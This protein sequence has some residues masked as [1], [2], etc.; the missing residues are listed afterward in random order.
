LSFA[1]SSLPTIDRLEGLD[2]ACFFVFEDERPVRGAAGLVDW[3]LCGALSRVLI[4][5]RFAGAMGDALLFPSLGRVP[6]QRLFCFGAGRREALSREVFGDLVRRACEAMTLAGALAFASELP[7]I[8][9]VDESER[10][11]IFL[12]QG[13]A[14]FKG[15][16]IVLLGEAR[17]LVRAFR[18]A[19]AHMKGLSIDDEPLPAPSPTGAPQKKA[20]AG[21][22]PARIA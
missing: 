5:G 3:R 22:R 18:E 15:D 10:A 4:E 7:Q 2:S 13:A 19:A 8:A 9:A 1:D 6:P 12:G 11:R 16:R 21:P 20:G 14:Y 17:A